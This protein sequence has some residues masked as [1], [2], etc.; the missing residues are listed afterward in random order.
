MLKMLYRLLG[1]HPVLKILL[2]VQCIEVCFSINDCLST[3]VIVGTFPDVEPVELAAMYK[4]SFD[5]T[6]SFKILLL[7]CPFYNITNI[8]SSSAR[9]LNITLPS[10]SNISI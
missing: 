5:K 6:T 3:T 4:L 8:T 7:L 2:I 1:S 9:N 10:K